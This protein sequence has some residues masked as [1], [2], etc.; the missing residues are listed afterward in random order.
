LVTASGIAGRISDFQ[1]GWVRQRHVHGARRNSPTRRKLRRVSRLA[2]TAM[3]TRS[4]SRLSTARFHAPECPE[5]GPAP[6]FTKKIEV[7]T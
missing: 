7:G 5:G 3:P 6:P 1:H 2:V 4:A